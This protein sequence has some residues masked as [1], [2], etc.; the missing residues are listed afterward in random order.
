MH[1]KPLLAAIF[2]SLFLFVAHGAERPNILF[3]FA[4][5]QCFDTINRLGNREV[6][7]PN[8]DRLV[9]A[10][11]TFTHAY[12]MG[13]WSGAVCVPSRTML[14][15]GRF[16]WPT[17][18]LDKN[19][20]LERAAGRLWALEMK[21][22]GYDTYMTGKW[23]LKTD[24]KKVFDVTRHIRD[25]MPKDFPEGYNR[26][27]QGQADVWKPWD[28]KFG[29]YWE[30]GKHW[31]EVM[32]D[33]ATEFL[34]SSAKSRNPFFMYIAFNAPHDPRQSPREFVERY[35]LNKIKVPANFLPEYPFKDAMGCGKGLRDERLAPF[36]RTEYA[37]KVNRQEYYALITHMDAQI[38]RILDAL[39]KSPAARNTCIF[40]TADHGLAV[41][42]HGLIGKQNLFD[43]SVRVPLM[44]VGPGIAK[45]RK[46]DSP[47]Y[48][49]DIMPTTIELA[50]LPKPDYV[51]FHS[52][53]PMLRKETR[54]SAY[55]A[56]YGAY[57][58]LQR[59]VTMDGYKL[60]LYP[61]IQKALLFDLRK[62]PLEMKDL[63]DRPESLPRMKKLFAR[64]RQLQ[65]EMGDELDL[66]AR[67]SELSHL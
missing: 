1:R 62:D 44:V 19:L 50:G 40:F 58:D 41:G 54:H 4:D 11:T 63:G 18:Q 57:L 28:T 23:H 51:Q 14:N 15:T 39:D 6:Q 33:D 20:E 59:A 2:A 25:G 12:N 56:I 17:R 47:V 9:K 27:H 34:A 7:T 30:G 45:G 13:A 65:A 32:G 3:I 29:G 35:P 67:Y 38:G 8:L 43:H 60:I 26:P 22:A 55:D 42:Q 46:V 31:S 5:D 61:G 37:V 64:L 52:L 24:A 49:Q 21:R 36:P 53:L 66:A 16:L 48:L 10:G